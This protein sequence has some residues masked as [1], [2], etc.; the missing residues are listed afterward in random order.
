MKRVLVCGGNGFLG[1]NFLQSTRT[2]DWHIRATY[3]S[4][5][6]D[7]TTYPNVEWVYADLTNMKYVR[8]SLKDMDI[9]V[10][11]AATTSG[12]KDI[13]NKPYIHVTD[14]AVMNSLLLRECFNQ[15]IEHFVFPSCTVM[16][17]TSDKPL[18][19]EDFNPSQDPNPKYFGA[20]WTKVYLEKMCEFYSRLSANNTKFTIFRHS[21]IYGPHDKY[22]L[23]KSHM[24]AATITKVMTS[25]DKVVVWGDGQEKRDLLYVDDLIDFIHAAIE[26]QEKKHL[27]LNVGCGD[28]VSVQRL[29]ETAIKLSGKNL[30]IEYD[31][32]KPTIPTSLSLDS[33]KAKEAFGW[34]PRTSLEE[35]LLKTFQWY[36]E[37][38]HD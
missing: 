26:R 3:H 18:K 33:S 19:E 28:A 36:K 2:K 20:A 7:L 4:T 13:L 15:K 30:R 32:T 5:Q 9:V 21:N 38:I 37:N 17:Q 29:V 27:L 35:G 22:D 16:Y 25:D 24:C 11:L 1:R 6:P 31:T 23:E 34:E 10:Q 14:N 12:A 8:E